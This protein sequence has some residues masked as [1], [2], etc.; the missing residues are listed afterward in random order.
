MTASGTWTL[1]ESESLTRRIIDNHAPCLTVPYKFSADV[2]Y[3]YIYI[4]IYV[5][6]CVYGGRA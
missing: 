2:F 1:V 5:C 3:M 6:V 4:Y